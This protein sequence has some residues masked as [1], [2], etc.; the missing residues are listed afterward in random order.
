MSERKRHRVE[1]VEGSPGAGYDVAYANTKRRYYTTSAVG[2]Q[3]QIR[4]LYKKIK[5]SAPLHLQSPAIGAG[6]GQNCDTAGTLVDL[7]VLIAEGDAFNQRFGTVTRT[8]RVKGQMLFV[9]GVTQVVPA[10]CRLA[11]FRAPVGTTIAATL[12][13]TL[14]SSNPI[15]NNSISKVFYD[16]MFTVGAPIA[17]VGYPTKIYFN[18]KIN[19]CH[20]MNY[21]G[22]AAG[23]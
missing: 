6:V 9:P 18:I 7:H 2:V 3:R 16:K 1:Y 5:I 15:A 14:I 19:P 4:A 17:T 12:A 22:A 20:R 13:N 8:C 21:A 11:V 23:T 10:M